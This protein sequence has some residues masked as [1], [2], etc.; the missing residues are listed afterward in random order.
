MGETTGIAW[1]DH[2]WNPWHGCRKISPGCKNCYM[3][4]DKER[5]GQEP[6][7]VLRSKTTFNDP[8]K[9]KS[10]RVFTCSWS[11]FFI[12]EADPWRHEAWEIIR[13]TPHLTY[14]ILTKRPERMAT[15]FPADWGHGWANVWLGISAENQKYADERLPILMTAK[16]AKRFVSAEPLL[17]PIYI[18]DDLMGMTSCGRPDWVIVGGES[19]PDA[20]LFDPNWAWD[21]LRQCRRAE[22]AFFMKQM[23]SHARSRFPMKH[24]HGADPMEWPKEFRV[25]EFPKD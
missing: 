23:G 5:Y 7:V 21:L 15:H 22:T 12:E 4:R 14:Q 1:T 20:R 8:L 11:D 10:G 2:T 25:Q 13:Q 3:Y 19:G 16:A 24:P 17:E 18:Q 6:S 9:W